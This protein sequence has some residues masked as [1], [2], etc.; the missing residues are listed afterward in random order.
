[1]DDL[2]RDVFR[3]P[4]G[5]T[6]LLQRT[7]RVYPERVGVIHG[8]ERWTYARLADEVGRL[9]GALVAA[10]I[11]RG[12]RVAV[13]LPNTPV[14]LAAHFAMPLLE[15]PLV[16]INTRLAPGEIAYILEHSGARIL[17]VDPELAPPLDEVLP[18]IATLERVIEVADLDV[19]ARDRAESYAAFTHDA[20][21][22]PIESRL[23]D[24]N[25]LLSINYTSGTTGRPKGVMY[26]HRGATLNALGQ[27]GAHSLT[28]ETTFLWTLPMFH[29]NGW[30]MPWAVTGA[31]GVHLGLRA[32]DPPHI[33]R[34]IAEHR[35][36]H[37]NAAPTVLLMLA[38]DPAAEGV[39]FDPPVRVCTGGAPPSPTLLANMERL[40]A[41]VTH[42]YG[43]TETYGPHV[44][45]EMQDGWEDLDIETRSQKMS[46]QGV[47]FLFAAH[48]RVVD[49]AMQDVPNDAETV[50]EVVM[51]GNNVMLGYFDDPEATEEAFRGGW[52]HSGDLGVCH[53]DTYIELRD[54]SKDIIISGGENISTIEVENTLYQHPDVQEVAVVSM[55][56]EK[57]GEVPKAF[58]T[59]R[60][61]SAPTEDEI[62]AFTRKHLAGFKCPKAIEFCELP[63]TAT[64][65][66]Q[67]FK[68]REKAWA[69]HKKRIQG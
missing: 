2:H 59:R 26:S 65:K 27:I 45:C 8:N 11:Q 63:K 33:F 50:G 6:T 43:L 31:G 58:V 60:P 9:A 52:F 37:F 51:R 69:G 41:R 64:G 62:I 10:G 68:L 39:H 14:H 13:L 5:P 54:R 57:W 56:H 28:K 49:E 44:F 18:G 24:E 4:L 55:P 30:C 1:M 3:D 46:R 16:S 19:P 12:D 17:L 15:A 42:L 25:S 7:L 32:I 21:V 29:C 23:T 20:P 47:P 35:V 66:I 40:G 38:T 53:P 34:L 61:G 36:T 67:K 48:L 22:L